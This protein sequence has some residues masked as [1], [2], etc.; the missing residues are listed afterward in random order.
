M[1][2]IFHKW[3]K[4]EPYTVRI[5]DTRVFPLFEPYVE[6]R[7]KRRCHSCGTSRDRKVNND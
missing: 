2:L 4:W 7:E 6:L 3:E 1:C 5:E